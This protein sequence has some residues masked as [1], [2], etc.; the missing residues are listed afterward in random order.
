MKFGTDTYR[1]GA[2]ERLAD[3]ELLLKERRYVAAVYVGGLAVEGMLRSLVWMRDKAFDERHDL[4]RLAVRVGYLGLLRESGRDQDF[5][6]EV[7]SIAKKWRNGMRFADRNQAI[8]WWRSVGV[9][10][11]V[12]DVRL[13]GFCVSFVDECSRVVRRC[14]VLWQRSRSRS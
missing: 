8:R 2:I 3:A 12:V 7:Q 5:V 9:L 1:A 11:S 10:S 13:Q 6:G 4:R 14:E